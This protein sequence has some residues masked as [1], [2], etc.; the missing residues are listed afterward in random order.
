MAEAPDAAAAK[1][2]T[3][4]GMLETV[5]SWLETDVHMNGPGPSGGRQ[6]RVDDVRKSLAAQAVVD[7]D[8][9]RRIDEWE[10][11]DMPAEVT[12]G[13]CRRLIEAL[14]SAGTIPDGITAL[15]A[16]WD[17]EVSEHGIWTSGHSIATRMAKYLRAVAA[18]SVVAP[19]VPRE[20]PAARTNWETVVEPWEAEGE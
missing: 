6:M 13:L 15:L 12:E 11:D 2:L 3:L 18:R 19:R 14:Q 10:S 9:Q 7:A 16:E 1:A 5:L 20:T 8:L 17:A 4:R